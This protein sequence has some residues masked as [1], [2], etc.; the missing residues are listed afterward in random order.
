MHSTN[1]FYLIACFG[2]I[3]VA[4]HTRLNKNVRQL[5]FLFLYHINF[6]RKKNNDGGRRVV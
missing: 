1:A 3:I 4:E 2:F 6:R 5:E